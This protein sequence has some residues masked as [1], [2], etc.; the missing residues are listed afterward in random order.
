V[1]T[2][3]WVE[4]SKFYRTSE[5]SAGIDMALAVMADLFG[6]EMVERLALGGSTNAKE[7]PTVTL[8]QG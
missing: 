7:M 1:K 4:D 6:M 8:S 5:V 2:A 3:R